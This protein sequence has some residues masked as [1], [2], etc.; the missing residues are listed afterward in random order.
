MD[1]RWQ[2][3]FWVLI[4]LLIGLAGALA[5]IFVSTIDSARSVEA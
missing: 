4:A 3:K 1:R 2:I 5:V